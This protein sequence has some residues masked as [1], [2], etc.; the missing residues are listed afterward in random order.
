MNSA[1]ALRGLYAIADTL[2]LDAARLAPAVEQA[3]RGGARFIQYRDKTSAAATR[4][5]HAAALRAL[6]AEYGAGFIVNDDVELARSVRAAGVHIG[7]DDAALETARRVLGPA[8]I[9]GVSCYDDI[10]R[11]E[12]AVAHGAG[13]IAFGSFFAS[14]TKPDAVRADPALLRAA[15]ARWPV[16]RVAIG[17]IT[18]DNGAALIAAGAD[19]LAVISGV[20]DRADVEQA[21]RR[22]AS[23]FTRDNA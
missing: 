13:Y 23:L 3:L 15:R 7:R 1:P 6:C 5:A 9:I 17:G 18:P 20:F 19:A 4:A 12:W 21:A 10:G 8:A 11:A 2:Y 22:Y 14:R 16:P